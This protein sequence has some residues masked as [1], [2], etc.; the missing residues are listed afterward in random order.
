MEPAGA[1]VVRPHPAVRTLLLTKDEI[2]AVVLDQRTWERHV[3]AG[4]GAAVWALLDEPRAVDELVADLA[5][6]FDISGRAAA[7][8]VQEAT[9]T[10]DRLGILADDSDEGRTRPTETTRSA[11]E[12]RPLRREHD[13]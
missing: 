2:T 5:S 12:A 3:L 6:T 8:A 13:P 1:S 9:R 11:Q 7:S 10:F 4:A